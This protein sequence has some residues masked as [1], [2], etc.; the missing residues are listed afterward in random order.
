MSFVSSLIN[1]FTTLTL[2]IVNGFVY[3]PVT[4]LRN[5]SIFPDMENPINYVDQTGQYY[6]GQ[7]FGSGSVMAQPSFQPAPVYQPGGTTPPRVFPTSQPNGY[8]VPLGV[9]NVSMY[10]MSAEGIRHIKAFE[11]LQQRPIVINGQKYIGYGH[12]LSD[13][14]TRMYIS[15]EEAESLLSSDISSAEGLVKG[16]ITVN[17]TQGQFDALVD[18]A[19]TVSP[20]RFKN[21][22]IIQ[23]INSGD[24]AG[25]ATILAQWVYVKQNGVIVKMPH[26]VSRRTSN[27]HWMT[28]PVTVQPP[29]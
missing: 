5:G 22:T 15:I 11:G 27:I 26:L 28:S 20:Q 1:L 18:F 9:N 3:Q 29:T 21:S 13:K 12:K 17:L 23:K 8:V 24:V 16:A 4:K 25:A 10:R 19:F 7:S 2:Q 14:D 6:L